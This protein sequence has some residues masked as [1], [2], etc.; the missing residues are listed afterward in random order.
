MKSLRE[1]LHREPPQETICPRCGIPAPAGDVVCA[2]C[3]WDLREAYKNPLSDS[4]DDARP[5]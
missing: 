4:P 5:A 1:L 2:A 3:G